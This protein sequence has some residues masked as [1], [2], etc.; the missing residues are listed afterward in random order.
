V[1]M[2]ELNYGDIEFLGETTKPRKIGNFKN[3]SL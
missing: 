3:S 2:C 1:S